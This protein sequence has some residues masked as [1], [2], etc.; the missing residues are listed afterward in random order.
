VERHPGLNGLAADP[1][2]GDMKVPVNCG[3]Q[4]P[5]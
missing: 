3:T 5:A 4:D 2:I 1:R